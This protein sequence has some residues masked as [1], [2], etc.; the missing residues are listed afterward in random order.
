V[1]N[2]D[3]SISVFL[4]S[5]AGRWPALDWLATFMNGNDLVRGFLVFA[6]I[7]F[8][9]FQSKGRAESQEWTERRQVLLYTILICIPALAAV[10]VAAWALPFRERPIFNS[11]LHLRAAYGQDYQRLLHWN[12]FPSDTALLYFLLATGVFIVHR[13]MGIFLYLHAFVFVALSRLYLGIHYPSDVLAGAALGCAVGYT[14]KWSTLRSLVLRPAVW[15]REKSL[16]LFYAALFFLSCET[17]STYDHI[18]G[19]TLGVLEVLRTMLG[20]SFL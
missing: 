4:N 17:A 12:A 20:H 5:F 16:G 6:V 15:L 2:P 11:A 1:Q 7:Y 9:W 13:R 3:I 10:R 18:R 8:L 14:A 19:A